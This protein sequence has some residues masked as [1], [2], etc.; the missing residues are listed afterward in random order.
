MAKLFFHFHFIL[1]GEQSLDT[2]GGV[3]NTVTVYQ[4]HRFVCL[5]HRLGC[6]MKRNQN[7]SHF[8]FNKTIFV[9][10]STWLPARRIDCMAG[11]GTRPISV[12]IR[13]QFVLLDQNQ[14]T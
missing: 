11:A 12:P 14:D 13:K 3:Y 7:K 2:F 9:K 6:K 5:V 8:L 1:G 4:I 10:Y